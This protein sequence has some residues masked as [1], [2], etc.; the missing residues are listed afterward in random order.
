MSPTEQALAIQ[1]E[2]EITP[3][4]TAANDLVIKNGDQS[5]AAQDILKDI[6]RRQKKVE[7]VFDPIVDSQHKAWK[8]ACDK[9]ASFMN[10]LKEAEGVIKKKVIAY[11]SEAEKKRQDDARKAEAERLDKEAKER[12]KLEKKAQIAEIKGN[13]AKAEALRDQIDTVTVAPSFATPPVASKAQGTSFR[14]IWKGEVTDIKSLCQSIIDGRV[15]V[16][17][18]SPNYS[19]INKLADVC[20]GSM[21]IP[22]LKFYEEKSMSVRAAA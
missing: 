13:T 18:F 19:V 11:E 1:Y 8:T 22:G 2:Q 14:T 16:D 20:K 9:R 3:I 4:V 21:Q 17:V 10:P 5:L 12:E 6:K 15:A 7:E